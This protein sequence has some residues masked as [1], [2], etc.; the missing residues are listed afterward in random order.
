M[1]IVSRSLYCI[2]PKENKRSLKTLELYVAF[3]GSGRPIYIAYVA[4]D[5]GQ[6]NQRR[7]MLSANFKRESGERIAFLGNGFGQIFNRLYKRHL[8]IQI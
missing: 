3:T 5:I 2:P 7:F 4:E 6:F 8:A 1:F